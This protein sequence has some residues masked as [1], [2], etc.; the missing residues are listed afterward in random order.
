MVGI[1]FL[2]SSF[3]PVVAI[4]ISYIFSGTSSG[5]ISDPTGITNFSEALFTITSIGDTDNIFSIPPNVLTNVSLSASISIS[6]VGLANFTENTHVFVNHAA[7]GAGF[8]S[9]VHFDLLDLLNP[10][11]ATWDLISPIGPIF[12]ATP[13]P[14]NQFHNVATNLGLLTF[15]SYQDVTF[16]A[17]TAAAVPE[18]STMLLLGSGLIG[19]AGYGRK[20]FFKK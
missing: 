20:K 4:P 10:A 1:M 9:S 5:S 7:Q 3:I 19:L 17:V 6:G 16:S 12:Y 15:D 11:F 18:P 8:S 13:F 14:V 2:L